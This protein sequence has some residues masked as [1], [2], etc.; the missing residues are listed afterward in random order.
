VARVI[1]LRFLRESPHTA[2]ATEVWR[3]AWPAISHMVLVTLVFLVDRAMIGRSSSEAL[4]SMQISGTVVW[5]VYSVFTA[6]SAG[7]LAV[8][9]RASGS[10]DRQQAADAARVSLALALAIGCVVTLPLW[11]GR[12]VLLRAIFPATEP[13]VMADA[14]VY[15]RIVLPVMPLAFLEAIA[16]ASLQAVGDTRTPLKVA[17]VGGVV[18]LGVSTPLIFGLLGAPQLG[19]VGAAIGTAI[20]IGLEAVLLVAW[21]FSRFSPLPLSGI[22]RVTLTPLRRVL[23][24]SAPAFAERFVYHVGYLGFTV[25]IGL[26][27]AVAMAANQALV[28]VESICFLSADG[29]GIAAGALVA[30]KLGQG[31]ADEA[32]RSGLIA[33]AMAILLLTSFGVIFALFPR[34]LMEAFSPDPAIVAM[35]SRALYVTAIAQPFMATAVVLAMSLRAAGDT[36]AVLVVMIASALLVRVAGTYLFAITL[37][38]GLV[39]VWLG[40]TLDWMVRAALL[41]WLFVRGRWRHIVV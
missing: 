20:A 41:G 27:G 30:Q 17:A 21:L 32:E 18:K 25:I 4:A 6:F 14:L 23:R 9:A 16:A 36:R 31:R 37:D 19:I 7:T 11:L 26:L 34:F 33:M 39:G 15:L 12:G 38:L 3:L 24:I 2:L 5:T 35:G 28:S 1:Q 29:F 22:E 10:G 8:V 40:S 13:E